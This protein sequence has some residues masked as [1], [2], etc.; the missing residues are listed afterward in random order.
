MDN[1]WESIADR[2]H[3]IKYTG[4][5]RSFARGCENKQEGAA[6]SIQCYY[7]YSSFIVCVIVHYSIIVENV[8]F[9]VIVG[10]PL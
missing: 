10:I 7:Y 6:I 9:D 4:F 8:D 5:A 3:N 1:Y 2:G